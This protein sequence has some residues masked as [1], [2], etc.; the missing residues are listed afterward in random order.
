MPATVAKM[1]QEVIE[2]AKTEVANAVL[3]SES[4]GSVYDMANVLSSYEDYDDAVQFEIE[5]QYLAIII[6]EFYADE[7][8]EIK[9]M[10]A[11]IVEEIKIAEDED[12]L[13]ET[14]TKFVDVNNLIELYQA[15]ETA[16][17]VIEVYE[18]ALAEDETLTTAQERIIRN[19]IKEAKS[20]I[21]EAEDA[22][23]VY[24]VLD[25]LETVVKDTS[26][27]FQNTI[28]ELLELKETLENA[29]SNIDAYLTSIA[30]DGDYPTVVSEANKIKT[31][32]ETVANIEDTADIDD[33]IEEINNV[34]EYVLD[35]STDGEGNLTAKE[36]E[37]FGEDNDI[38]LKNL[39]VMK[40]AIDK[41]IEDAATLQAQLE[42]IIE[43][44]TTH[45]NSVES[46][47]ANVEL[48]DEELAEIESMI[49]KTRAVISTKDSASILSAVNAFD[50]FMDA[51]YEDILEEA[52]VNEFATVKANAI[53]TLEEYL[54]SKVKVG[55]NKVSTVAKNAISDIEELTLDNDDDIDDIETKLNTAL[56][57]I[58]LLE[59]K[60]NEIA[61]LDEIKKT[62][63]LSG[64]NITGV[65]KVEDLITAIEAK[66]S[67]EE[68]QAVLTKEVM[69]M[70]A[71]QEALDAQKVADI[72]YLSVYLEN[73][74]PTVVAATKEAIQKI[75]KAEVLSSIYDNKDKEIVSE[76]TI[77]KTIK[78]TIAEA[79][80]A[81]EAAE[82]EAA[83]AEAEAKA[84]AK[85]T[86]KAII[87]EYKEMAEE[88]GYTR[89]VNTL[90]NVYLVNASEA[91]SVGDAEQAVA[92][93][94]TFIENFDADFFAKINA[95]DKI[96]TIYVDG[97]T[98]FNDNSVA[99]DY[100]EYN[101]LIS[102][103]KS[104]IIAAEN[105]TT[106]DNTLE[107]LEKAVDDLLDNI[108]AY[109]T[110]KEAA[111]EKL[112]EYNNAPNT[113]ITYYQA[114]LDEISLAKYL[115]YE[116]EDETTVFTEP[117]NTYSKIL[118]MYCFYLKSAKQVDMPSS[119]SSNSF[120]ETEKANIDKITNVSVSGS[121][122]TITASDNLEKYTN[123]TTYED[124]YFPILVDLGMDSSRITATGNY[125]IEDVDKTA[126][127]DWGATNNNQFILWLSQDW[128]GTGKT[129]TFVVDKDKATEQTIQVNLVFEVDAE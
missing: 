68:A 112:A 96:N 92:D 129:L 108:E 95:I 5:K 100:D 78:E 110:D 88:L 64:Y 82:A 65:Y 37:T 127:Y 118:I 121:T 119:E 99:T 10:V 8:E 116:G 7:D 29:E 24:A 4:K 75:D 80:A 60:Y 22:P 18:N 3:A 125:S 106:V 6:T 50:A 13:S 31:Y 59:A 126:A 62:L 76:Q 40:A 123:S 61:K 104:D 16:Y 117:T 9:E 57:E 52:E 70:I 2:K 54:E 67:V 46:L 85:E 42:A 17:A 102:K 53:A 69:A 105:I 98:T 19:A 32:I 86:A 74:D 124:N 79:I 66:E 30:D 97:E 39:H 91:E 94:K 51:Y 115:E 56:K 77:V 23:A 73:E 21:K 55:T 101:T 20:D 27:A 25:A 128:I 12:E 109:V 90:T 71:D 38:T 26:S 1:I 11:E 41:A 83:A 114:K 103:A 93:A 15:R 122:I 35:D 81:Q 33:A 113:L 36:T 58:E 28:D 14:I 89:V 43:Y 87:N 84:E 44:T 34:I 63:N 47:L 49:A 48:E 45:L 120:Y 107:T 111:K 72:E